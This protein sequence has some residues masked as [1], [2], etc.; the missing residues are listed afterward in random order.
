MNNDDRPVGFCQMQ[1]N[2]PRA[3]WISPW[4]GRRNRE[5][6]EAV[7]HRHKVAQLACRRCPVLEDCE[8]MLSAH[9]REGLG[10]DG[11]VAGRYTDVVEWWHSRSGESTFFQQRCVACK[12]KMAPQR[13]YRGRPRTRRIRTHVGEGLCGECFPSFS[14]AARRGAA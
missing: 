2:R 1:A 3:D 13:G 14:R 11:I 6:T 12:E 9:E 7:L 10:I 8:E 4:E 5:L